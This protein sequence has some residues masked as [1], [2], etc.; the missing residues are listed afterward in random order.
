[1]KQIAIDLAIVPLKISNVYLVGTRQLWFLVDAGFPGEASAIKKSVEARFGADAKPAS[2]VL[3]HGHLDHVGSAQSLADEWSVKVYAPRLE[4][5]YI[6]GKTQYPPPDPTAPGFLSAI[7]RFFPSQPVNLGDLLMTIDENNPFPGITGW[8]AITTPGH[9]PGHL[10]YFRTSDGTLLA[11]DAFTNANF[12]SPFGFFLKTK[13]LCRPPVPSTID[14]LQARDS[15][16]KLARLQPTLLAAGHGQP[17][18]NTKGK[19]QRLADT[20]R[21]PSHGRYAQAPVQTGESGIVSL[22]PAPTDFVPPIAKSIL[23][24]GLALGIG[25]AYPAIKKKLQRK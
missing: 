5:P 8:H 20:F 17:I 12:E 7:S 14:W 23:A 10:A 21:I 16:A 13:K 19:L 4:M 2:I 11:G 9:S 22:P 18:L 25:A 3:T 24:A 1:M 6:S 15:V